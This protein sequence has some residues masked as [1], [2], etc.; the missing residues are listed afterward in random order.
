M[1]TATAGSLVTVKL[2]DHSHPSAISFIVATKEPAFG[3]STETHPPGGMLT[4][5][6]PSA[7]VPTGSSAGIQG[8]LS[9]AAASTAPRSPAIGKFHE[10]PVS[11]KANP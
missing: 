5:Q 11:F 1:E 2:L 4:S 3:P 9:D 6:V 8:T 7:L 10:E